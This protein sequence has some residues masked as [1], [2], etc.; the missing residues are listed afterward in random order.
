MSADPGSGPA[1]RTDDHALE[2][3]SA[4][5][6]RLH[7]ISTHLAAT[8]GQLLNQLAKIHANLETLIES[9]GSTEPITTVA[10]CGLPDLELASSPTAASG[11]SVLPGGLAGEAQ[12]LPAL[13]AQVAEL[14]ADRAVL[15]TD[16]GDQALPPTTAPDRPLTPGEAL[17]K[18]FMDSADR[19]ANAANDELVTAL[20]DRARVIQ[21][22]ADPTN[23]PDPHIEGSPH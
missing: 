7:Q 8:T 17:A 6:H 14:A 22:L 2:R 16:P 9:L 1:R 23:H 12:T 19:G 20:R 3:L 18:L 15:V 11:R 13:L 5:D 10:T 21:A 4:I